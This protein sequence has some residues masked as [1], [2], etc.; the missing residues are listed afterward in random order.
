[1]RHYWSGSF[2]LN[3]KNV[4]A[5]QDSLVRT[6]NTQLRGVLDGSV[7]KKAPANREAKS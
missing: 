1:V 2:E 7:R 6:I 5:A 4:L 3:V